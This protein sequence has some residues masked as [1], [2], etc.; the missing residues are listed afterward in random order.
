MSL[1]QPSRL[2]I[3]YMCHVAEVSRSG[4]Y[5]YL[6]RSQTISVKEI[7]DSVDFE[8][9]KEAF[10]YRGYDKGARQI[11]MVLMRT[12]KLC[13]NLKKIRRLM[14][15]NGLICSIR[16]ANP[17]RQMMR[18]MATNEVSEN[19]LNRN[20]KQGIARKV[21]LTDI[22]YITYGINKRAY[23]SVIKDAS[24]NKILSYM[25]SESL[26]V[27]FVLKTIEGLIGTQ[28]GDLNLKVILH[29]DQGAHY[30]SHVFRTVLGKLGIE[31]SMSRRGNCLDNSAQESFF[32]HMK[33]EIHFKLI[34]T[35]S[36]CVEAII[37]YI[38]YYNYDRP[39]W[40]LNRLTPHEYERYLDRDEQIPLLLP[41]LYLPEI[42]YL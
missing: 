3:Q 19:K 24:T 12:H 22:T 6:K 25:T 39:Q 30:T 41:V 37:D 9:I 8:Y 31:S 38:T 2:D 10:K 26:D 27:S 4:Y 17:Y 40:G 14:K 35:Y 21:L 34:K 16:K 42:I 1:K 5:A 13:M 33:D 7:Q 32:G 28:M 15:K 20:F 11:K 23:L 29:S 36:E 18:E